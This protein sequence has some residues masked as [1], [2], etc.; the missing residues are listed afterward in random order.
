MFAKIIKLVGLFRRNLWD[1]F[2]LPVSIAFGFYHGFIK[3][4]A[5]FTWNVVSRPQSLKQ[6]KQ[7]NRIQTSWG[8]RPDG[9]IDDG[10]RMTPRVLPAEVMVNPAAGSRGLIRYKDEKSYES[11]KSSSENCEAPDS[12]YMSAEEAEVS[13]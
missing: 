12:A 11:E 10:E 5:L 3:I 4:K 6:R 2:F 8:S 1:I 13:S 7:L 9:D